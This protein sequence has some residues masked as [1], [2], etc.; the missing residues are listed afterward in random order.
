LY[1]LPPV[2]TLLTV[3]THTLHVDF[4][5]TDITN[6]NTV[7]KDVTII[8]KDIIKTDQTIVFGPLS[9][10]TYG[11]APF[12]VLQRIIWITCKL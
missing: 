2:G 5:P 1:I 10:T 4:T 12:D 11:A 6:Y 3:G 9:D 7:S 8:V